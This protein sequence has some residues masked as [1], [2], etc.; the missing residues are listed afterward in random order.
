MAIRRSKLSLNAARFP[1]ISTKG[2]RAV[3][4]PDLDS[5]PR[6]PRQ[7]VGNDN[8]V[9]Y[10]TPQLL[11][12]ENV[13]PVSEGLRS[14][15]WDQLIPGI[16][17]S[18][19]Q[20][21]IPLRNDQEQIVL[22]SPSG[23]SN[24]IYRESSSSWVSYP[25]TTIWGGTVGPGSA[26]PSNTRVTYAYV[27]GKTI[28]CYARLKSASNNDMS[29]MFWDNIL[30]T[31][32]PGVVGFTNIPFAPGTIDGI[33]SSNGFLLLYSGI[34]VAWARFNGTAFDFEPYANGSFTGSGNQIPEDIAGQITAVV[35]VAGGF[36]MFSSRN[37]VAATYNAQNLVSPWT[38]REIPGAGG[39]QDYERVALEGSLSAL[40][41][42]TTAG[43]QRISLNSSE[44]VFPAASDFI[45]GGQVE[46][47]NYTDNLLY[48]YAISTDLQVK[49]TN[50]GNRYLCI[51]YGFIPTFYE[52]ILVYDMSLERWGKLKISHVD[53]FNYG[54]APIGTTGEI[55]AAQHAL[56][57]LTQYGGIEKA[58]WT[59]IAGATRDSAVAV[60][61]RV[62]L[63][64][65]RF[66]QLNRVEVEKMEA[67]TLHV[68][69]SYDGA[70]NST[71]VQFVEVVATPYLKVFGGEV[72]CNNFCLLLRG[73][74]DL[75]TLIFEGT[76]TGQL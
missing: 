35:G 52:Y 62:A 72:D 39:V 59:D 44:S 16:G 74:F 4:V 66:T 1:F 64:R 65:S 51:S 11:Y 18:A 8:S 56:A 49:L 34:S 46:G 26:S 41:A 50:V 19:F 23:G 12:C 69:P 58:E 32:Q 13:M 31:L 15:G 17:T 3:L 10:N 67:G 43:F 40:Y 9:D 60:I 30:G 27:D 71:P 61:G 28:I 57:I 45:S 24:Y 42:Y 22:Y 55:I 38:F 48:Q 73:A 68:I 2:S 70:T 36:V 20:N 75:S 25:W 63:S 37:A 6:T 21:L 76:A 47:F 29:L 33:A 5:A 54:Y 53:C 14:A 7:F